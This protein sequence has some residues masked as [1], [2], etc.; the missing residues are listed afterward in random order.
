M[1]YLERKK[2]LLKTLK[3]NGY[4]L[5]TVKKEMC[6][7]DIVYTYS[8]PVEIRD[9]FCDFELTYTNAHIMRMSDVEFNSALRCIEQ[10]R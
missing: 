6:S 2:L 7:S 10:F 8:K 5:R 3:E 4:K 9:E 1:E